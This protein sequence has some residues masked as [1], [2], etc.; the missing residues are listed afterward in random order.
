MPVGRIPEEPRLARVLRTGEP[1]PPRR[2]LGSCAVCGQAVYADEPRGVC[3]GRMIHA[4]C[5]D[6]EWAG[7]RL[8]EKLDRLGYDPA[9][10]WL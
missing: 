8:W 3:G 2:A 9:A 4:D 7:L 1:G 5:A 10:L 6:D